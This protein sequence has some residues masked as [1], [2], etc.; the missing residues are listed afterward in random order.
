[1]LAG[2][3][4]LNFFSDG[5][6]FQCNLH[7]ARFQASAKPIGAA[8]TAGGGQRVFKTLA[9]LVHLPPSFRL[10]LAVEKVA[11]GASNCVNSSGNCIWPLTV[12]VIARLSQYFAWQSERLTPLRAAGPLCLTGRGPPQSPTCSAPSLGSL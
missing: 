1:M 9:C 7:I 12:S 10:F 3:I 8:V 6:I 2:C 4:C 5:P 11:A